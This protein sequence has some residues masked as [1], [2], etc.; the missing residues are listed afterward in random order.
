MF[1]KLYPYLSSWICTSGW[2]E[3]GED[4]FSRSM[5]RIMNEGGLLWED[6]NSSTLDEALK[7]AEDFLKNELP[8]EFGFKLEIED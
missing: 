3:I 1:E 4:E 7:R 2:V 5:I 8:N 6:E